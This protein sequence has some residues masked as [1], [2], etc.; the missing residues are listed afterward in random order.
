VPS[1][2]QHGDYNYHW[3]VSNHYDHAW[4]DGMG[5]QGS[6]KYVS[7]YWNVRGN[8]YTN[9]TTATL[10]LGGLLGRHTYPR[11]ERHPTATVDG[12]QL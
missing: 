9:T 8:R 11:H 5:G 3:N 7:K 10:V 12:L 2:D 6:K 4:Q 1:Y